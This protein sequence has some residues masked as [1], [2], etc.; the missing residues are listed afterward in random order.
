MKKKHSKAPKCVKKIEKKNKSENK[1]K[2]KQPA[3]AKLLKRNK[4]K[5]SDFSLV[6]NGIGNTAL[7]AHSED[8]GMIMI[9][10]DMC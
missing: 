8:Q 5:I 1:R 2:N 6:S 3:K 9:K 10:A 4:L 7:L